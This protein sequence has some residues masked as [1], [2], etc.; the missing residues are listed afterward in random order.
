MKKTTVGKNNGAMQFRLN[1]DAPKGPLIEIVGGPFDKQSFTVRSV[2][3]P[4]ADMVRVE[5]YVRGMNAL[6]KGQPMQSG[7]RGTAKDLYAFA[8]DAYVVQSVHAHI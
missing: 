4:N 8:R 3:G 7:F 6:I 2:E 1:Q 5:S